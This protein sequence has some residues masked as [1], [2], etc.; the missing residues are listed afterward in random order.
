MAKI[1]LKYLFVEQ[2]NE[3]NSHESSVEIFGS[4][5]L[6]NNTVEP[7]HMKYAEEDS[8]TT[9]NITSL[10]C[11]LLFCFL[12]TSMKNILLAILSYLPG[13]D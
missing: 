3:I 11:C 6:G 1:I 2:S 7:T 5:L 10:F 13:Q 8:S 9:C 4:Y 12:E